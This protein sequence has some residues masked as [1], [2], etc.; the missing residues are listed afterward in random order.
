MTDLRPFSCLNKRDALTAW[1]YSLL[2]FPPLLCPAVVHATNHLFLVNSIYWITGDKVLS[3]VWISNDSLI[4]FGGRSR[5]LIVGTAPVTKRR[6]NFLW[7]GRRCS[8]RLEVRGKSE[9]MWLTVFVVPRQSKP[10][11]TWLLR[12]EQFLWPWPKYSQRAYLLQ[13]PLFCTHTKCVINW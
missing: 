1:K 3:T 2:E 11:P 6:H 8:S 9:V 5:F 12:Q 7:V 10:S 4:T 13:P